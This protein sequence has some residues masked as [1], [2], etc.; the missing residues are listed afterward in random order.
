MSIAVTSD[1][2]SGGHGKR[3][4]HARVQDAESVVRAGTPIFVVF[5]VNVEVNPHMDRSPNGRII[6]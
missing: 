1:S 5:I 4:P 2:G 6:G 3:G